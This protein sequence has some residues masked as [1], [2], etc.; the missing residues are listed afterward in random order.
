VTIQVVSPMIYQVLASVNSNFT[1]FGNVT[2]CS[3]VSINKL[4][5]SALKLEAGFTEIVIT[6]YQNTRRHIP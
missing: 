1:V 6:I 2:Q 4:L 5:P 3:L